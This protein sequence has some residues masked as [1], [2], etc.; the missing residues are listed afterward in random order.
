MKEWGVDMQL[1]ARGGIE[2]VS[3]EK[4][5]IPDKFIYFKEKVAK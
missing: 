1:T 4:R 5:K 2:G 3:S